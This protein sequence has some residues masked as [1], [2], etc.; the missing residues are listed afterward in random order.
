MLNIDEVKEQ[1]HKT[2]TTYDGHVTNGS[3]EAQVRYV[4]KLVRQELQ[5][6][7]LNLKS[8]LKC[9]ADFGHF[10]DNDERPVPYPE[11][12]A[13]EVLKELGKAYNL[14]GLI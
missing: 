12:V 7:A 8:A 14:E 13:I 10:E 5:A 9:A 11:N 2:G 1:L 6:F 3:I 4:E